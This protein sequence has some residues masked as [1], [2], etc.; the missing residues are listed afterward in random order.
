MTSAARGTFERIDS[1]LNEPAMSH[2]LEFALSVMPGRSPDDELAALIARV[3]GKFESSRNYPVVLQFVQDHSRL[4]DGEVIRLFEFIYSSMVNKFKGELGEVLARPSLL[5]FQR[6]LPQTP[7]LV[8]G[9]EIASRQSRRNGWYPAADALYCL[10]GDGG[11]EIVAVAEVKSKA[12]PLAD[13]RQQVESNI[14]R[15][16]RGMRLRG[17]EIPPDS[18]RVRTRNG[19]SIPIA[20]ADGAIAREIETLMVIPLRAATSEVPVPHSEAPVWLAELPW[21]Q[22]DITEAAYRLMSWYFSRV[23]PKVFYHRA[24]PPAAADGRRPAP[25]AELSLEKNGEHAFLEAIYGTN[26]RKEFNP[27]EIPSRGR[28]TPWQTLLWLYNSLGFGYEQAGTADLTYPDFTPSEASKARVARRDAAVAAFRA[29][30][31]A[32]ALAQLPDPAEQVDR[33]WARREWVML[34]R[35]LARGGDAARAREALAHAK[36]MPPIESLSLPIEIA[37]VEALIAIADG[38]AAATKAA[39]AAGEAI[40][41]AVR[42]QVRTHQENGWELPADIEPNSAREGVIDL[43]VVRAALGD[44][45]AA[46]ALLRRLRRLRGWEIAHFAADPMLASCTAGAGVLDD[47]RAVMERKDGLA[48]F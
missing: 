41:D 36:Q 16:R 2:D 24:A 13:M 23:G 5:A 25:H 31:F 7:E 46:L 20:R 29:G 48:I 30:R 35:V 28:R 4:R 43:A 32:D 42:A 45:P 1:I 11:I 26:R 37:G 17:A 44:C 39:L 47:L 10:G 22:N 3:E 38:D 18:I 33:W 27:N 40:L 21:R 19:A 14:L 12:T 9:P 8:L 34:A 15:L 6:M